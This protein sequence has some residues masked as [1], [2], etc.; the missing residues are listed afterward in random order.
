MFEFT[1]P[2][3]NA[4][5]EPSGGPFDGYVVLPVMAAKAI[6]YRDGAQGRWCTKTGMYVPRSRVRWFGG[7]PY[8]DRVCPT[9]CI[10]PPDPPIG[11]S[12]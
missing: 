1:P 7:R 9:A 4:P 8:F 10:V 11:I 3:L 6:N 2:P 12:D 5:P